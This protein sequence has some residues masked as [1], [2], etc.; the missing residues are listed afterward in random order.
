MDNFDKILSNFKFVDRHPMNS[1]RCYFFQ[2]GAE[3][4]NAE[5]NKISKEKDEAI[6]EA[7][8]LASQQVSSVLQF[9]KK[10]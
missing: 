6:L 2:Q 3:Q 7:Q 10:I 8:S 9:L 5:K 1:I 4:L